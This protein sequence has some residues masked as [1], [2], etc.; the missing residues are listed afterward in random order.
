MNF[1]DEC[2]VAPDREIIVK[3]VTDL[4]TNL[5]ISIAHDFF[6]SNVEDGIAYG[7][8]ILLGLYIV[9]VFEVKTKEFNFK[10]KLT[11]FMN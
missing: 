10:I 11:D 6:P 3:M 7:A 2:G 1:T 8:F 5:S 4:S 9:I